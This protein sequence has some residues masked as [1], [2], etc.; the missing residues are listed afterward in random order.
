VRHGETRL[1][2]RR[3]CSP[4][5]DGGRPDELVVRHDDVLCARRAARAM[6]KLLRAWTTS[7]GGRHDDGNDDTPGGSAQRLWQGAQHGETKVSGAQA[8][9]GT[10]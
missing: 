3:R 1:L 8:I 4:R 5:N 6:A 9:P 7:L 2:T 10:A